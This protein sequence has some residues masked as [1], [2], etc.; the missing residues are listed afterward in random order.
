MSLSFKRFHLEGLETSSLWEC[1]LSCHSQFGDI[2]RT[3]LT[4]TYQG[5]V[6]YPWLSVTP[7]FRLIYSEGIW[8]IKMLM[9]LIFANST[10]SNKRLWSHCYFE[11]IFI[12]PWSCRVSPSCLWPASSPMSRESP[13]QASESQWTFSVRKGRTHFFN[14]NKSVDMLSGAFRKKPPEK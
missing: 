12:R 7:L 4:W 9:S 11:C 14:S 5:T 8:N 2:Y 1:L 10:F 3:G 13:R 6:T